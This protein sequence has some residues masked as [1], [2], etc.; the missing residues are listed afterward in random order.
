MAKKL[1]LADLCKKL[2]KQNE[3]N[4]IISNSGL[5]V[6]KMKEFDI[7]VVSFSY[8]AAGRN[9]TTYYCHACNNTWSDEYSRSYYTSYICCPCCDKNNNRRRILRPGGAFKA[10]D[11]NAFVRE[12][13]KEEGYAVIDILH[14]GYKHDISAYE[15]IY[16]DGKLEFLKGNFD[17]YIS[18]S[19]EF[20]FSKTFGIRTCSYFTSSMIHED[21]FESLNSNSYCDKM[22]TFRNL[23]Y[24]ENDNFKIFLE[25]LQEISEDIV[26]D[27]R[28]SQ[29]VVDLSVKIQGARKRITTA[30]K[31]S[32]TKNVDPYLEVEFREL[33]SS[34]IKD[35]HDGL[36]SLHYETINHQDLMTHYCP[37]CKNSFSKS[38]D[39]DTRYEILNITCP[40]CGKEYKNERYGRDGVTT[41]YSEKYLL[42]DLMPSTNE[43][44]L[45]YFDYRVVLNFE[46]KVDRSLSE[47]K[48]VFLTKKSKAIYEKKS[49][50]WTKVK[51]KG[52]SITA[53]TSDDRWGYSRAHCINSAE[54][55]IE[56][57]QQTEFK[58]SGLLEAW[59]LI[60]SPIHLEKLE[61]PGTVAGS[62]FLT[63]FLARPYIE[64]IY[65]TG[66]LRA[67][68]NIINSADVPNPY[69]TNVYEIL[70]IGKPVYK[71]ARQIDAY[72]S[73]IKLLDSFWKSDNTFDLNVYNRISEFGL[74]N[75]SSRMIEIRTKYNIKYQ[76]QLDYLK[77]CYDYQCIHYDSALNIWYD[78]LNMAS[79]MKYRL[80]DASHKYPQSLK[81]EHDKAQ[82][83][84]KV[85]V[86]RANQEKF[87][88]QAEKNAVLEYEGKEFIVKVP[89]DPN[90]VIQEGTTLKHCVASYVENVRN[91]NT[92]VCFI[93][94]KDDPDASFF[95]SEV[96]NG[97]VNQVKG[98]TNT[99]P[100]DENLLEFI[101]E[102]AEKKGLTLGRH[103]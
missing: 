59:G 40:H 13:N 18:S 37:S 19:D 11:L 56:I 51:K 78:Y 26:F 57:I 86:D 29:N 68:K 67:T 9:Q 96:L 32:D 92:I 5:K 42:F 87:V 79:K 7:P 45:R 80:N 43:L 69:G 23:T 89:R 93:R 64:Q 88:A 15:E 25:M 24:I 99:L 81:K 53:V 55:L 58:Y 100:K 28:F 75:L 48:R 71:M 70:N 34:D 12:V 30:K 103:F 16:N 39:E 38:Y 31:S 8:F 90:E 2:K 1:I 41:S 35:Q 65:K 47:Y 33:T 4:E 63:I 22:R 60:E 54:Q 46:G 95:T 20:I 98:Y 77:N 91:G 62:S 73:D 83:S 50:G 76:D 3:V 52:L 6:P 85:V 49:G 102:W 27:E 36:L 17:S 74:K 97:V 10:G 61:E 44:V 72:L 21:S 94:K 14:Y 66:L 84:Y 101:N 82:F